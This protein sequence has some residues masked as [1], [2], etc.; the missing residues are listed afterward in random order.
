MFSGK[1]PY[2]KNKS[3]KMEKELITAYEN[4][5][6]SSEKLIALQKQRIAELELEATIHKET[7]ERLITLLDET[8][9]IA[10]SQIDKNIL[11]T[12]TLN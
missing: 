3:T 5:T 4:L 1:Y 2:F 10:K 8:L 7:I 11:P 6:Q 12:P 9:A